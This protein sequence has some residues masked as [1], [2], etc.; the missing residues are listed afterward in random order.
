[1]GT[2]HADHH[3]LLRVA[4]RRAVS[5]VE[6]PGHRLASHTS[7][8][9][10]RRRQPRAVAAHAR[11]RKLRRVR[12][13]HAAADGTR[14]E[15]GTTATASASR[16]SD[17]CGRAPTARLWA[18]ADPADPTLPGLGNAADHYRARYRRADMF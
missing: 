11:A 17:A 3:G 8:R 12:A 13:I 5:A 15:H 9:D 14:R 16:R 4:A 6:H 2:T 7:R 18:V 10:R 1:M